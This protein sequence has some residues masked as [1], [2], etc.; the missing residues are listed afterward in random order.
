MRNRVE[1]R[2]SIAPYIVHDSPQS[3]GA[4][5]GTIC[6]DNARSWMRGDPKL[7]NVVKLMASNA[8]TLW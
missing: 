1:V 5:F 2:N 4:F 7:K 8:D 6:S 3:P